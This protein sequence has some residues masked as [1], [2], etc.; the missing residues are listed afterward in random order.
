MPIVLIVD[1]DREVCHILKRLVCA[2]GMK[3]ESTCESASVLDCLKET[4]YDVMLLDVMMPG[5]SGLDLL[6]MVLKAAP[7]IKVIMVSGN[8]DQKVAAKSRRLGASDFLQKPVRVKSLSSAIR[9]A[10]GEKAL[11]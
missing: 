5:I 9:R 4:H 11:G 3:A 1:D 2:L 8:G 10:L 6:P 7:T